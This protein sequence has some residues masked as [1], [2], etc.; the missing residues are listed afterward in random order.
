MKSVV[1]L[2]GGMDS[3]T[4]LGWAKEN[5]EEVLAVGF[6]YGSKHNPYEQECAQKLSEYFN[7]E[8]IRVDLT[9]VGKFLQSNLLKTGGSIPEGHYESESMKQTVVPGRN[10]IFTSILAGI[11]ESRGFNSVV[12]GIHSGDHTIYPDCRPEFFDAMNYA[13]MHSSEEKVFLK[14][15]FLRGN[16]TS[17]LEYGYYFL[18]KEFPYHLTRT[19]YKDQELACG[20]CGACQERLEAFKNIGRTDPIKYEEE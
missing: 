8:F 1:S 14:A 13:V 17:I 18:K 5:Y 3:G 6:L 16:K 7:V 20:K 2:S 12:L 19:C 11:A 4:A 10:I 15:P 9:P